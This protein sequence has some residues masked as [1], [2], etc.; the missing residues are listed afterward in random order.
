MLVNSNCYLYHVIGVG[1]QKAAAG[2]HKLCGV[3]PTRSLTLSL[4]AEDADISYWA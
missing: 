4:V 1:E 2:Q 3:Q